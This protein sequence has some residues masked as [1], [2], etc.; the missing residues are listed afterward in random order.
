MEDCKNKI[1]I[2]TSSKKK[3]SDLSTPLKY[4]SERIDLDVQEIQGSSHDIVLHKLLEAQ[5]KIGKN[6]IL[7]DDTSFSL[8][9]LY[10]FP[11]QYGKSFLDMYPAKIEDVLSKI[12]RRVELKSYIGF[13]FDGK[14]K[15]FESSIKGTIIE[16]K[17]QPC[18][19]YTYMDNRFV[20]DGC[21]VPFPMADKY[22]LHKYNIRL[23]S[24]GKL[25][26]FID[27]NPEI[28]KKL[29]K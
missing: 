21:S 5:K 26:N 7:V 28:K 19:V 16:I 12:G 27:E 18:N 11:A 24:I 8:E 17:H 15:I 9:G 2:V 10:G 1:L 29:I 14:T 23:G 4:S 6:F 13:Y 25:N 22:D 20:P 3:F